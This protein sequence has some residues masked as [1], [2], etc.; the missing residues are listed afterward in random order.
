MIM[1]E[2]QN[3]HDFTSVRS[4]T[5]LRLLSFDIIQPTGRGMPADLT[6][7]TRP[8]EHTLRKRHPYQLVDYGDYV[9]PLW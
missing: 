2:Y 3:R 9:D 5:L 7:H 6:D 1:T 4:V 8:T